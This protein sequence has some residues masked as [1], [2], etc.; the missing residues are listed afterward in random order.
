VNLHEVGIQEVEDGTVA[1]A[2][3]AAAAV[4]EKQFG[5]AGRRDAEPDV[6]RIL[7]TAR[8]QDEVVHPLAV[9]LAPAKEVRELDCVEAPLIEH[10]SDYGTLLIQNGL[11]RRPVDVAAE[12]AFVTGTLEMARGVIVGAAPAVAVANPVGWHEPTEL[13]EELPGERVVVAAEALRLGDK[14]EQPLRVATRECRHGS[15]KI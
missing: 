14:T 6:E 13:R 12:D 11:D 5:P 3:I 9:E 4:E 1:C 15:P 8:L 10:A 7:E 2:E